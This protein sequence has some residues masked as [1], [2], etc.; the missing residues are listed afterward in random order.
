M[1]RG[2]I[3]YIKRRISS[4]MAARPDADRPWYADAQAGDESFNRPRQHVTQGRFG[5]SASITAGDTIWIVGQL[6][7]PWGCLPPSLDARIDVAEVT[8]AS[9]G[10]G[11][12]QSYVYK[13]A[14]T[15]RWFPIASASSVFVRLTTVSGN[16]SVSSL[17]RDSKKPIGQYLQQI[18]E[19]ESQNLL[20]DWQRHIS[21]QPFHFI[22]YR[23][24]DGTQ[25]AFAKA[26]SLV[27][28]GEAIF[29]DRWSLPRRLAERR[30]WVNDATLDSYLLKQIEA[31]SAVWGISSPL[32]SEIDSYAQ[33]EKSFAME[34][35]K[36][37]QA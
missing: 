19:L 15:S 23:L 21:A 28:V 5:A 1:P 20:I 18:R 10:N 34:L 35:G 32:Y 8:L 3:H 14:D 17:W 30:E 9:G 4:R 2:F 29:W 7:S 13:A 33:R 11:G 16:G 31:A 12:A 26:K 24:R 22:S 6:Y 37:K 36:F 25:A 27:D